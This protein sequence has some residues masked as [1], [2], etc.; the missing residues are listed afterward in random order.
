M[1]TISNLLTFLIQ[2]K[3]RIM[4][5]SK[6]KVRLFLRLSMSVTLIGILFKI[7]HYAFAA[8]LLVIGVIGIV[9]FY[10]ISFY[11]KQQKTL[12]DYAKV[13]LLIS[14]LAHYL[15]RIL[16]LQFGYVFTYIFQGALILFIIAYVMDILLDVD[17]ANDENNG[18]EPNTK[19]SKIT[20]LLYTL[21]GICVISGAFLKIMHWQF[22]FINGTILLITGLLMAVISL[23]IPSSK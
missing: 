17:S 7:L 6:Q 23:V 9:I 22:G 15:F 4:F 5:I 20:N 21:T 19:R 13:F 3:F 14:F 10:G 1:N 18:A 11:Q 16:H 8:E 12:L 2:F